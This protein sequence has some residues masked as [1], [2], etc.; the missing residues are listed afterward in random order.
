[1]EARKRSKQYEDESLGEM[2]VG[3]TNVPGNPSVR[4]LGGLDVLLTFPS[5][6]DYHKNTHGWKTWF[7]RW[8]GNP[9]PY[10]RVA[11]VRILGVPPALIM[12]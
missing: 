6:T 9:L 2:E 8:N 4:Y 10:E 1:M 7:T 12:G 11:W 5:E 3:R